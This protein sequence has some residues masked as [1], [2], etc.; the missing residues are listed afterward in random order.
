MI[1]RLGNH[2]LFS[3]LRDRSLL[4]RPPDEG[5]TKSVWLLVPRPCRFGLVCLETD[6]RGS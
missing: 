6:L 3:S 2:D 5:L 1:L 4:R